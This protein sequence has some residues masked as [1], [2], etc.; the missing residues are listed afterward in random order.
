M[1]K[2]VPI[3]VFASKP[4]DL[5]TKTKLLLENLPE[6]EVPPNLGIV[7]EYDISELIPPP[8][9]PVSTQ[10]RAD[11]A[12]AYPRP[13]EP[14]VFKYGEDLFLA[15]AQEYIR[16]TYDAH[17]AGDNGVQ[18]FDL[19]LSSGAGVPFC[20]GNI[21]KYASR[22]GKKGGYNRKDLLKIIHYACLALHASGSG[23]LEEN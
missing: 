13:Q 4:L 9:L 19:I 23:G 17:Y 22:Y 18:T 20:V 1:I 7:M 11:S 21:L 14:D 8:A 15:A 3:P 5:V 10:M 2:E 16:S 6:E 12:S